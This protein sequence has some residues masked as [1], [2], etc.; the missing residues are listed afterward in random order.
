M[1]RL[2]ELT[3]RHKTIMDTK[4]ILIS[5]YTNASGF[6]WSMMKVDSGTDLGWSG[7]NG[8]CEWSGSFKTYEDALED[9][10]NLINK[11]DLEKFRKETPS[12]S[13]HWGNYSNHLNEKYRIISE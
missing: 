9:A 7:F 3:K 1:E 11:C 4:D 2:L 13:F 12:K 6:L 8:N 5:V 10:L